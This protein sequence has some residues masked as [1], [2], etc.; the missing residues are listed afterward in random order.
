MTGSSARGRSPASRARSSRPAA[1]PNWRWSRPRWPSSARTRPKKDQRVETQ[2]ARLA[3]AVAIGLPEDVEPTAAEPLRRCPARRPCPRCSPASPPTRRWTCAQREAVA[4]RARADRE[5]AVV[6]PTPELSLEFERLSPAPPEAPA[7][8][9]GLRAGLAFDLPVLNQNRGAV[10]QAQAEAAQAAAAAGAAM[11]R[12]SSET[13]VA[14]ARWDAAVRR[15]D[16]LEHVLVP[17]ALHVEQLARLAYSAAA[18]RSSA[19]SRRRGMSRMSRGR[20]SRRPPRHGGVCGHGGGHRCG[21]LSC[22]CSPFS[23]PPRG[24]A[25]RRRRRPLPRSRCGWRRCS[26]PRWWRRS[27]PPARSPRPRART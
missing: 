12:R 23:S 15:S 13:R 10:H 20:R 11:R 27:P 4:A 5:G 6:R 8:R 24:V 22:S 3:L 9:L 19:C 25:A 14:H 2:A 1:P 21:A 26:A 18:R 16:F 7:A 17:Q